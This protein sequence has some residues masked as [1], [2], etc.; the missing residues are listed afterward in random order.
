VELFDFVFDSPERA[1][2]LLTV[3]AAISLARLVERPSFFSL[4]TTFLYWRS[5]LLP[6]FT[7]RGGIIAPLPRPHPAFGISALSSGSYPSPSGENETSARSAAFRTPALKGPC[8]SVQNVDLAE[9]TNRLCESS[10]R[11]EQHPR[12]GSRRALVK[13]LRSNRAAQDREDLQIDQ[14]RC[15]ESLSLKSAADPVAKIG[16]R[17][18][19]DSNLESPVLETGARMQKVA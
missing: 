2:S 9:H 19:Q 15:R 1:F 11:G 4:L 18:S 12:R 16:R 3:R 6:S 5:R 14:L 13:A 17:G 10:I 7:P 8:L